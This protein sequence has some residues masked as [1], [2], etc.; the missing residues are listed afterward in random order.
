MHATRGGAWLGK[1]SFPSGDES[2]FSL[3]GTYEVCRSIDD[4][5]RRRR[6]RTEVRARG[7]R[8]FVSGQRCL[9]W[10]LLWGLILGAGWL[11]SPLGPLWGMLFDADVLET[12]VRAVAGA[13]LGAAVLSYLIS[14]VL[15]KALTSNFVDVVRYLDTSP[16]S[17]EVRRQI[18]K[19]FIDLLNGLHD[20]KII[21]RGKR[22][23][24]YDRIVIVAHS[25]GA[26][27]AYDGISYLWAERNHQINSSAKREDLDGL[28]DLEQAVADF[29]AQLG[30]ETRQRFH[31]A[32]RRLWRGYRELGS[33][34][35]ITD[36]VTVGT[37]M[38]FAHRLYTRN[39]DQFNDR[40]SSG[41]L[42][43]CP[44]I[45]DPELSTAERGE[46][47][48]TPRLTWRRRPVLHES[49]PF[50]VV[51]WTNIWFPH[52]L[53]F[54]GDWFGGGL[55]GLYGHGVRDV[56][57]RGNLSHGWFGPLR[58]RIVPAAPHAWYFTYPDDTG[59]TSATTALR[60]ALDLATTSFEA[61]AAGAQLDGG[62]SP[63][64]RVRP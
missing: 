49:A 32:Q 46:A 61:T 1:R 59:P 60:D 23:A 39:R 9:I 42:P 4:T 47:V 25:L 43:T 27:I 57:I 50:A 2:L 5:L 22:V 21:R 53:G 7:A 36:L 31:R 6:T 41:E 16:R 3:D 8:V 52:H 29:S 63:N 55:A 33:T 51:R 44:P 12:L 40:T 56:P 35:R 28:A 15:P 18:R 64:S 11:F 34:W 45:W 19:G 13:G 37:P 24:A 20:R 26:Y 14:R 38:Y 62:R 58:G 10:L 30:P 48:L 54:F 17:Y